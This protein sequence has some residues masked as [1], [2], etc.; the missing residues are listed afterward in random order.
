M[1]SGWLT[2]NIFPNHPKSKYSGKQ[3]SSVEDLISRC[4]LITNFPWLANT[5]RGFL[6]VRRISPRAQMRPDR[7][8]PE[9]ELKLEKI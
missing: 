3:P 9:N 2:T 1:F 8:Y 7:F 4:T 6:L 5:T